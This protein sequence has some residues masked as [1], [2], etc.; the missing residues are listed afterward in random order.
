MEQHARI[1]QRDA[2]LQNKDTNIGI[3][4][5]DLQN[6]LAALITTGELLARLPEA[7][8]KTHR[9][10]ERMNR[11]ARRMAVMIRDILDYT[12]GRLAGGIPLTRQPTDLAVISR[13]VV[14]E[15][16]AGY[17]AVRIEIETAGRLT[18]DW[19]PARIEQALSNLIA[20]AVQH[21]GD[22]VRLVASG[23]DRD[24]VVVT[25]RNGGHPIPPQQ[26]PTL[27]DAFQKGENSPAGLGL[28]LFIVR[29]IVNAHEGT[30]A[31]SSSAEGTVFS[32]RL[33]RTSVGVAPV[34]ASL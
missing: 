10:V 27:F 19:D 33:P 29:E 32:F 11:S 25:V 18:G 30:V 6:P 15:I 31:V 1:A 22:D 20:N 17:P 9:M 7:S 26:L 2:A 24:Q 21:G 4:A 3:L 23:E 5:H 12:R 13:A 34:S 8:G 16:R 28:G 14:D